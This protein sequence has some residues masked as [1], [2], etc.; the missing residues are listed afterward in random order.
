MDVWVADF[1]ILVLRKLNCVKWFST[2]IR[3]DCRPRY[4]ELD[5][6]YSFNILMEKNVLYENII[7]Y[8]VHEV[9]Q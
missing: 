4:F 1:T 8:L 6:Y 5:V 7:V 9:I 2:L 3:K